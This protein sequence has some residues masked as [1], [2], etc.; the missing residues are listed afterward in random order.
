MRLDASARA[1]A[2]QPRARISLVASERVV[3]SVALAGA[4][5]LYQ[6][7][8]D[9]QPEP[10]ITFHDFWYV[11]GE[12]G[13]PVPYVTHV[14]GD[15][16]AS[17]GAWSVHGTVFASSGRGLGELRPIYDQRSGLGALRFGDA[18][19]RGLETR[20]AVGSRGPG[21]SA[22]LTYVL[23]F[24]ERRWEDRVWRPWRLDRRHR[25][26]L[27]ALKSFG[28]RWRAFGSAEGHSGQP[29]TRVDDVV[30]ITPPLFPGDSSVVRG[31]LAYRYGAEGQWRSRVSVRCDLGLVGQ[32][33]GPGR[34]SISVGLSVI[35]AT[36]GP[37]APD[38]PVEPSEL[39]EA[40]GTFS[41][42][43][44]RYK[45]LFTLPPVPSVLVRVEF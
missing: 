22:A 30:V 35:N 20:V 29:L 45:R 2:L 27:E 32:F 16:D 43:G 11:A 3:A 23:S 15:V 39:L 9:P 34:S 33:G 10:T 13:I 18:R 28:S 12:T 19:T 44:V 38:V 31:R 25:I 24:S 41:S 1:L 17:W 8:T 6:T 21:P 4:S 40:D 26:R 36:F 5:R 37:V 42:S 14:A 7:I